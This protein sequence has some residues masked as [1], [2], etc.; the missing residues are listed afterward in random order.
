MYSLIFLIK[1]WGVRPRLYTFVSMLNE[2]K[3]S[4]NHVF[5]RD[6]KFVETSQLLPFFMGIQ[7][8]ILPQYHINAF[9]QFCP[10]IQPFFELLVADV[11]C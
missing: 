5:Q 11:A 2:P 1:R 4:C 7:C 6:E 10:G 8:K 9:I 3:L